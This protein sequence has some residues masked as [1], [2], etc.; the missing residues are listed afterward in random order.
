M[1]RVA[2]SHQPSPFLRLCHSG[3]LETVALRSNPC[4]LKLTTSQAELGCKTSWTQG[5]GA[6]HL[7]NQELA[8]LRRNSLASGVRPQCASRLL[9]GAPSSTV[10]GLRVP[11]PPP[12]PPWG[13]SDGF[14]A[15]PEAASGRTGGRPSRPAGSGG[16]HR[17]GRPRC[18]PFV[19]SM[20]GSALCWRRTVQAYASPTH[21]LASSFDPIPMA[22]REPTARHTQRRLWGGQAARG[23]GCGLAACCRTDV[24]LAVHGGC[25]HI[26]T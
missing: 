17:G 3:Q 14:H 12:P 11:P 5:A 24:L 10:G 22:C 23:Q 19:R 7:P 1:P 8:E 4:C 15:C 16:P 13:P 21:G 6:L 26:L 9:P 20:G 18:A 2:F 25:D